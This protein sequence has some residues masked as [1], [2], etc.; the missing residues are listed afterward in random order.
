MKLWLALLLPLSLPALPGGLQL[1]YGDRPARPRS[2]ALVIESA[3][4]L[5][6]GVVL[7]LGA[8]ALARSRFEGDLNFLEPEA[9]GPMLIITASGVGG[10]C[11]GAG[12]GAWTGGT[13]LAER[14]RLGGALLG[15]LAGTAAGLGVGVAVGQLVDPPASVFVSLVPV[16]VTPVAG[17]VIGYNLSRPCTGCGRTGRLSLP[18]LGIAVTRGPAD[19]PLPALRAQLL[20]LAI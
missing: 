12:A 10:Y 7:G 20:G 8:A 16:L 14:G 3:T 4:A 6:G 2:S 15:S 9:I 18:G 13:L 1:P 19:R 17:A 11:L 5:T